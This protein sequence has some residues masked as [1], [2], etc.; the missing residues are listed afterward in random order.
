MRKKAM[1]NVSIMTELSTEKVELGLQQDAK[2]AI[3]K[4]L[5]YAE[6]TDIGDNEVS[7]LQSEVENL[8]KKYISIDSKQ[9]QNKKNLVAS[10]NEMKSIMQKYESSAKELGVNPNDIKEYSNLDFNI[11]VAKNYIS[12]AEEVSKIA[13][14]YIKGLN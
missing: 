6:I 4:F 8:Q 3:K 2:Q 14:K 9:I 13:R 5:D 12:N 10:E 11:K 1:R 7:R